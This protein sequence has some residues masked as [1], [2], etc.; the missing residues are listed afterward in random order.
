MQFALCLVGTLTMFHNSVT[1]GHFRQSA[2]DSHSIW[3]WT[4]NIVYLYSLPSCILVISPPHITHHHRMQQ[5]VCSNVTT[6]TALAC[7]LLASTLLSPNGCVTLQGLNDS[8]LGLPYSFTYTKNIIAIFSSVSIPF[9]LSLS[10]CFFLSFSLSSFLFSSS[11]VSFLPSFLPP[12][13]LFLSSSL[14]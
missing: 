3:P 14:P 13:S 9:L 7:I 1:A 8:H 12:L 5:R 4:V 2:A 11:L 10:F 6:Y